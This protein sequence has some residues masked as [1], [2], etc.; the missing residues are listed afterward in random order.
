MQGVS[1]R[2]PG[3]LAVDNIDFEL[4]AGEVHAL[5]GENG[6]GKSTLMKMLAG[7]FDDYTGTI[8]LDGREVRL[9]SPAVAKQ[10]GIAMIYQELSLAHPLSVAENLLAG[11]LPVR[12]ILLDKQGDRAADQGCC[13]QRVGLEDIDPLTEVGQLSQHEMQLIEI[14]KALGRDPR[15][16]VMD[17][18]TSA[19]T[20]EEVERLFRIIGTLK[21]GGPRHHLHFPPPAGDLPGGRPGDGRCATAGRSVPT[22]CARSPPA[23]WRS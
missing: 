14:A 16:I 3:T 5:V 1:K 10:N 18:P 8:F 22:R 9:S 6:A 4:R 12:G 7:A 2:F 20:R 23:S 17:E 19:L 11:R 15:I 13:W 21:G